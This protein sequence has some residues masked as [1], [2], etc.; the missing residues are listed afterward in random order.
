MILK[1]KSFKVVY[2]VKL[3][4][5]VSPGLST[6]VFISRV[7]MALSGPVIIVL[8]ANFINISLTAADGAIDSNA[9]IL[10]L[11]LLGIATLFRQLGTVINKFVKSK[12][13]IKTRVTYRAE[14]VDK[15]GKLA[16]RYIE[17]PDTFDLIKRLTDLADTQIIDQYQNLLSLMD[18]TI[19]VIGVLGILLVSVWWVAPLIITFSAPAFYYGA[20]AGRTLYEADR[21][22]SKVERQAE[23]LTDVCSGRETVLERTLFNYGHKMTA[24][25]WE[26]FEFVRQHTQSARRKTDTQLALSGILTVLTSGL[27]MLILLQPVGSGGLSVGLF[28]SLT[29]ASI[30]LSNTL[31]GWLPTV[32]T[33][34]TKDLEYLKDLS[35]FCQLEEIDDALLPVSS[36][37]YVFDSLEFKHV[38]FAYPDTSVTIL[39]DVSFRIDQGKHYAFV[40]ENGAGKTTVIK[41][42][43]GQYL[44][45]E[46][47]I[48]LNG[49]ELKDY[50]MA[51]LKGMF[52]IAYQ[53][54]AKYQVSIKE[55]ILL[56]NN[57]YLN[58][59]DLHDLIK[60][61]ELA[62]LISRLSKGIETPLGKISNDGIDLSG[63]QW[64]KIALARAAVNPAPV[65][66]LDEPT[67]ALDPI[68]ERRLYE[69]F[70]TMMT[71][72]TSLFISHRLGSIKLADD[73]LVFEN[74]TVVEQG[75]HSD[76]ILNNG[77]YAE[78]YQS[79]LDWYRTD[80]AEVRKYG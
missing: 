25:L 71:D 66:I 6:F 79:Q 26:R 17:N 12:F 44:N 27:M 50:S 35:L 65:K 57:N 49:K 55:N 40:G 3:A 59:E 80:K 63:G 74:G 37:S 2:I 33:K 11:F 41:L 10:A 18:I 64:Q 31:G 52:S 39:S 75:T 78:M 38:T 36:T 69:Q 46:G 53:D 61:F 77:K 45:Y 54:F 1:K 58:D 48:V 14:L 13:L 19:Q 67:A 32:L 43:T 60:D 68:S 62:D 70:E 76:L 72:K 4:F 47:E 8:T 56:G 28:I 73:I 9:M 51:E 22:V 30:S 5:N 29:A 16:Y 34:L 23:Y 7:L 20:K 15:R 42:L 21:K 24:E